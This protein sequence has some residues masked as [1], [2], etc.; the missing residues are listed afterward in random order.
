MSSSEGRKAS[1]TL[2][3]RHTKVGCKSWFWSFFFVFPVLCP[4]RSAFPV[5]LQ[6]SLILE[7]AFV[8]IKI[9]N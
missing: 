6:K 5:S 7:P 4:V 2:P 9:Q 3:Y 8:K 1:Q